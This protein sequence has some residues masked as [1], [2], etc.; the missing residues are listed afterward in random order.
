[1]KIKSLLFAAFVA[2]IS[3]AG[4]A[5]TTHP[6]NGDKITAENFEINAGDK[7]VQVKLYLTRQNS[8]DFTNIQFDLDFPEGQLKPCANAKGKFGA[9][10][11]DVKDEDGAI[12]TFSDNMDRTDFYPNHRVV[13]AN[14]TKTAIYANPCHLYTLYVECPA[15]AKTGEYSLMTKTVKYTSY[16]D[17]AWHSVDP[18]EICK[19]TVKG[20]DPVI[21]IDDVKV[22]AVKSYKTIE[23]GQIV[24]VKGDAKYNVM[25]QEIK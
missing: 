18:A 22:N 13:G 14:M 7:N 20:S 10:G 5:E 4:N 23:N 2:A 15:D 25:G 19:V 3:F 16:D 24:I 17:D 21:G 9:A 6:D 8:P 1:M 11:N 12:V